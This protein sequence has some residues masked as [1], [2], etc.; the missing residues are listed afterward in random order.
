MSKQVPVLIVG[1]SVSGLTTALQ[2]ARHGIE[3]L[4]VER[5]PSTSHLPKAHTINQRSMEIFRQLN[6][7]QDLMKKATPAK[8]IQ[9]AAWRTSF[10]GDKPYDGQ[11]VVSVDAFG[12]GDLAEQYS[13]ASPEPYA[14]Y[15]QVI[16]EPFLVEQIQSNPLIDLRFETQILD[17]EDDGTEVTATIR[18]LP[19][20]EEEVVRAQYAVGADGGRFFQPRLGY[21]MDGVTGLG[22]NVSIWFKAD[23]SQWMADDSLLNWFVTPESFGMAAG[24]LVPVGIGK[25][26]Q[27]WILHFGYPAGEG[28][29]VT[30]EEAIQRMLNLY[31]LPD[32]EMEVIKVSRWS[33]EQVMA[34]NFRVGRVLCTGDAIHRHTPT[35]GIGMNSAIGDSHNLAWKLAYVLK[36]YASDALLDT[37]DIERRPVLERNSELALQ[38]YF[39]HL[40]IVPQIGLIPGGPPEFN[41]RVLNR[42]FEDSPLGEDRRQRTHKLVQSTQCL[43]H[44]ALDLELGYRYGG[45]AITSDTDVAHRPDPMLN[46]YVASTDPGARLAHVWLSTPEGER[47]ST[48]DLVGTEMLVITSSADSPW[49]AAAE[50]VSVDAGVPIRTVVIGDGGYRDPFGQWKEISGVGEDGALLVRPDQHVVWRAKAMTSSGE[51]DLLEAVNNAMNPDTGQMM[52]E[53][54]SAE[55]PRVREVESSVAAMG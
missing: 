41:E 22:D 6:I 18:H 44:Q 25:K 8:N 5:H 12:G 37:F 28:A 33:S 3:T 19:T 32:L 9:K 52:Q 31:K 30:D 26:S 16:L 21:K 46:G 42:Y 1:G 45:P 27:E 50:Q 13:K 2:L 11:V 14:S 17:F 48:L 53:L 39:L 35:L 24:V 40:G 38:T 51:K 43:E 15:H 29:Q 10:G 20:G 4:V 47:V 34:D 49:I 54:D 7:T 55:A 23:L 36:G